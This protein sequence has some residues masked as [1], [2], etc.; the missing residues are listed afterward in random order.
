MKNLIRKHRIEYKRK[1]G[2]FLFFLVALALILSSSFYVVVFFVGVTVSVFGMTSHNEAVLLKSLPVKSWKVVASRYLFIMILCLFWVIFYLV[3]H[4]PFHWLIQSKKFFSPESLDL[5]GVFFTVIVVT[6]LGL[7]VFQN[8]ISRYG[9]NSGIIWN[10]TIFFSIMHVSSWYK[11]RFLIAD[12]LP[13]F[14]ELHLIVF[15][16][17]FYLLSFIISLIVFENPRFI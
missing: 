15:I 6:G 11:N 2:K 4:L 5:I 7:P 8:L 3:V 17:I 14:V 12:T 16:F 10:A 9:S 13:R 1:F